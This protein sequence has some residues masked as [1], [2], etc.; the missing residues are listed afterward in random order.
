MDV[1]LRHLRAL[2]AVVDAGTFTDAAALIG[3]SQAAVSRSI[4]ALET[5]LGA[6][7]LERSTHHVAL[8]SAGGRVLS[9]PGASSTRS[10]TCGGSPTRPTPSCGS[11]TPTPPWASTRAACRR[12]GPWP[13]PGCRWCSSTPTARRP[14]S[15]RAS[16]T[17][18]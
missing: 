4:A 13:I 14:V 12:R 6:R 17:S 8:T 10:P 16:P 7:M 11:A 1:Q 18:P 2:V 15:A 3:C 9:T 5:S